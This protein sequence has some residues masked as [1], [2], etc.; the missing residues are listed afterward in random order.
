M[1][2]PDCDSRKVV[3][4]GAGPAGLA[5]A[6][7]LA[8][9][10]IRSIVLEQ[11]ERVGGLSATI[12]YKDYLFDL[13]GHRFFT[14]VK[15]V[16]EMWREVLG[17]DL[18]VRKRLSRIYYKNKFFY[19]PLRPLNALAGLGISNSFQIAL[20]YLH[21]KCFPSAKED[22]LEEWVINRFGERLYRIFFKTYTEKVWGIPCSEIRAEWAAQRIKGLSLATALMSAFSRKAMARDDKTKV[23]KTLIDEFSYPKYGPG[24]MWQKVADI[25]GTMKSEVMLGATVERIRCSGSKI[26]ALEVRRNGKIDVIEGTEFISSM[27]INELIIQLQPQAPMEVFKAAKQ[28]KHRDFITVAVVIN[29]NEIFPDNWI[30]IHDARVRVGR[31]QNFKNWSPFMVPDGNNTCL[32]LEYFC[33]EGDD[34]WEMSNEQLLELAKRELAIL[35][36][37]EGSDIEDAKVVKVRKAYPVYDA[38]YADALCTIRSYIQ[39]IGNLQVIGRN[40]MHKYNNQDHS[41]LTGMLAAA[42]IQGRKYDLWN[43]NVEKAYHEEIQF[44]PA[45]KQDAERKIRKAFARIDKLALATGMGCVSGLV[46]FAVTLGLVLKGGAAIGPSMQLLGQYFYGYTVSVKGAFVGMCYGFI[47][48]FFFGWTFAYIRN[49]IIGYYLY[50]IK[51]RLSQMTYMEYWVNL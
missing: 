50:R 44:E 20:S 48:A 6:Y 14:K 38:T 41:M 7:E 17:E 8:K 39:Q 43:V 24:M 49:G 47:S 22:T 15:S 16:E 40:G 32:G 12:N 26:E 5:A 10:G 45:A 27:P 36:M 4:I 31:I 34:L 33:S 37:A 1:S 29:R 25:I 35:G 21:A 18:L 9:A 28:L 30:Y 42:N 3:I 11:D 2:N 23:I 13:G 46:L 51:R 19:Y